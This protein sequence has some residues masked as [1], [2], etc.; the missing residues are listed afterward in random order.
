MSYVSSFLIMVF[1]NA[2]PP[3][4]HKLAHGQ[5]AILTMHTLSISQDR[6]TSHRFSQ[7][8]LPMV[9]RPYRTMPT[10]PSNQ[11]VATTGTFITEHTRFSSASAVKA[12][13]RNGANLPSDSMQVTS[14]TSLKVQSI[15]TERQG[16]HGSSTL[17]AMSM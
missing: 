11:V 4:M 16:I 6:V 8:T 17:Q 5:K 1:H 2:M 14:S 3:R 7:R 15:G 10:S 9:K 13:I 12:S